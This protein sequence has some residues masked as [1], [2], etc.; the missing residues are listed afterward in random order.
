MRILSIIVGAL[1][2]YWI[3]HG[4]HTNPRWTWSPGEGEVPRDVV[5]MY[6]D[7]AYKQGKVDE[8]ASL[9][10]TPKTEDQVLADEILITG[11]PFDPKVKHVIAEGFNVA[12]HYSVDSAQGESAEYVEIFNVRGGRITSRERIA[13]MPLPSTANQ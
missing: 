1:F 8:A 7:T 11:E 10:F 4:L 9:F 5:F 13:R 3:A 12:V 2:V 6:M